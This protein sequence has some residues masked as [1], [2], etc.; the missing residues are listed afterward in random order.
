MIT[1]ELEVEDVGCRSVVMDE[2]RKVVGVVGGQRKFAEDR[3]GRLAEQDGALALFETHPAVASQN[4]RVLH[5][6]GRT[7]ACPY[8]ECTGGGVAMQELDAEPSGRRG[9]KGSRRPKTSP[10]TRRRV[11][12]TDVRSSAALFHASPGVSGDECL[13]GA[14]VQ[15]GY[16]A[17]A[18][19]GGGSAMNFN[20]G[21][22]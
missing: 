17:V 19:G 10:R 9:E 7:D 20:P 16:E 22:E 14:G 15:E 6:T 4:N 18:A 11:S 1:D 21:G 5:S 13:G 8:C 12:F 3:P 2:G